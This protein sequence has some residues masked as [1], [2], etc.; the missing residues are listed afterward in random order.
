MAVVMVE[1]GIAMMM[2]TRMQVGWSV[3]ALAGR[4]RCV[5]SRSR[6]LCR[7]VRTRLTDASSS[8]TCCTVKYAMAEHPACVGGGVDLSS[9][10]IVGALDP[11]VHVIE[12]RIDASHE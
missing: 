1:T 10:R 12:T 7:A 11:D 5:R 3:Y 8:F 4:T 9:A 6:I 2:M